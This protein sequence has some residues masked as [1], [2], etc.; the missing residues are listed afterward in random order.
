MNGWM[1]EWGFR[2]PLCTYMLNWVRKENETSILFL[3]L[4][5]SMIIDYTCYSSFA[6]A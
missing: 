1:N 2:P 4:Y 3:K 6:F 5:I